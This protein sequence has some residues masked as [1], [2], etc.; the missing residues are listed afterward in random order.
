MLSISRKLA[1]GFIAASAMAL[2]PQFAIVAIAQQSEEQAR[3]QCIEQ[4]QKLYP[5]ATRDEFI[6]RQR[7]NAYLACMTERGFKP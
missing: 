6:M 5:D 4:V 3:Q 2:S 1:L 7:T